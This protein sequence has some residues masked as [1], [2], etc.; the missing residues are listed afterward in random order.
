MLSAGGGGG[1]GEYRFGARHLFVLR[2][3]V[4]ALR[5]D[6]AETLMINLGRVLKLIDSSAQRSAQRTGPVHG[7]VSSSS[8]ATWRRL[9]R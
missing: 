5:A 3:R 8:V 2:H 4:E 9:A 6:W 1:A 7:G